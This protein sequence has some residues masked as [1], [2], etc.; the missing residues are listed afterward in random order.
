M[1]EYPI[2][3]IFDSCS[4]SAVMIEDLPLSMYGL[5]RLNLILQFTTWERPDFFELFCLATS[6]AMWAVSSHTAAKHL[7]YRSR[8]IVTVISQ[9]ATTSWPLTVEVKLMRVTVQ[10]SRGRPSKKSKNDTSQFSPHPWSTPDGPQR[11]CFAGSSPGWSSPTSS[12]GWSL[13]TASGTPT[14][15]CLWTHHS[16]WTAAQT[17]TFSW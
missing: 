7:T 17:A 11:G 8:F 6:S 14:G 13:R 12:A 10:Y 9:S 15:G 2:T 3:K 16:C 5:E 4:P 1:V